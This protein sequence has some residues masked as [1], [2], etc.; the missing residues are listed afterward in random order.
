MIRT[1][2]VSP[3]ICLMTA[4]G[5]AADTPQPA[6][7][8]ESELSLSLLADGLEFPWGMAFLPN[9]DLL[10]TEREGRLR[11]VRDGELMSAPVTGIP[12]DILVQGQGG[13]L[14]VELHPEFETNRLVYLTYSQGTFRENYT[15]VARARLNE[16]G[17]AL[18]DAEE[19]FQSHVP[20]KRRGRHY[21]AR[22]AFLPDGTLLVS[23][24]DGG[25]FRDESQNLENQ[26]GTIVRITDSG[27]LPE[28]NPFAHLEDANPMIYTYGNRNV[29]G[30]VYDAE[31]GRI[32]AHE[33]GPQGGDELN[34][35]EAGTN[36][37]WPVIT[38][39]IN[40]DGTIITTETEAEGM[41]QP[42]VKWAP[43]I[44]PSGMALY[45]GDIY[46]G[47]D[48]DLFLGA[49]NGPDGRKLVRVD[50]DEAGDVTGV[51][52]LLADEGIPFRDVEVGPDGYIYLATAELDGRLFRLDLGS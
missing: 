9:G 18:T 16:S 14:D 26:F 31:R 2:L 4:C 7:T 35:I 23:L 34:Y 20:G 12:E 32:Y 5:S 10:V 36:Y 49:M 19:I 25:G 40:Y 51:E 30:M 45:R 33:H 41:A 21:G 44:A 47:W 38:Y 6:D 11:L 46:P 27:G 52:N 48:G 22:L 50:L 37:G 43:S 15:V 3:I 13:L 17:T 29:Q 8:V 28:G 24:G 39:G 1:V 42:A